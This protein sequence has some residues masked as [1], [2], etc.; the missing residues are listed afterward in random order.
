MLNTVSIKSKIDARRQGKAMPNFLSKILSFCADSDLKAYK[1]I[2]EK[3][4]APGTTN[5]GNE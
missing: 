4:N 5:A 1:R 2:V 3:I